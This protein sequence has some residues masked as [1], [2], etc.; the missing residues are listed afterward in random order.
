[1]QVMTLV[2]LTDEKVGC[3]HKLF[4]LG[5]GIDKLVNYINNCD[6]YCA[7]KHPLQ[8]YNNNILIELLLRN[9]VNTEKLIT[10]SDRVKVYSNCN[11]ND[12]GT[13]EDV[14]DGVSIDEIVKR[15]FMMKCIISYIKI[16]HKNMLKA[17]LKIGEIPD[18]IDERKR[19]YW[20]RRKDILLN[21][22]MTSIF[23]IHDESPLGVM[24]N[25]EWVGDNKPDFAIL[26]SRKYYV[27]RLNEFFSEVRYYTGETYAEYIARN[28]GEH[29]R[30]A[31]IGESAYIKEVRGV[32]K[33]SIFLD[34][35]DQYH[36]DRVKIRNQDTS[37]RDYNRCMINILN[38]IV[39][40]KS[41]YLIEAC[42]V[43]EIAFSNKV[44]VIEAM[45]RITTAIRDNGAE[46]LFYTLGIYG[47]ETPR[48]SAWWDIDYPWTCDINALTNELHNI[49]GQLLERL[50]KKSSNCETD[51]VALFNAIKSK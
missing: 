14:Q 46:K 34:S 28:Y 11:E 19:V 5:D 50:S 44:P 32:K 27:I 25:I 2:R 37:M 40:N 29:E 13:I 16:V 47:K 15:Q 9:G 20:Q 4:N 51:I 23:S 26:D 24:L 17:D 21:K 39:D 48:K 31:E 18:N 36:A 35:K 6:A 43:I 45:S 1:M 8:K 10:W 38:E 30:L 42:G 3:G 22:G 41:A 33:R 7:V 12:Y 49:D